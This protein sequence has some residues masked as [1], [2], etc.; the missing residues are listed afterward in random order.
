MSKFR[1]KRSKKAV[2]KRGL[3]ICEGETEENYFRGLITQNKYKRKFQSIDVEIFKPK[4]HSPLGLVKE[5]KRKLNK[6]KRERNSYSFAWVVFDKDGHENIPNAFET[7]RNN[8]PRINIVF[9]AP[10][11]EYFILLHF[12]KTTKPFRK[13]KPV[14]SQI[15]KKWYSEYELSLIHI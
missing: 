7:A 2:G 15:K 14:V 4:D 9:T 8:A 11:F 10:C 5:C 1:S 13:C 12:E 3:I 6:A